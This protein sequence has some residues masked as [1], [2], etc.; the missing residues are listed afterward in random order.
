MKMN[1]ITGGELIF[2]QHS[3]VRWIL[4]NRPRQRNALG[5]A[6]YD[7]LIAVCRQVNADPTIRAMVLAGA[8]HVFAAATDIAL[9][10]DFKT[11]QEAMDDKA[12]GNQ[13]VGTVESV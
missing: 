3:A 11:E 13:V 10:Q 7:G 6:M 9:I 12:H 2:E 8:D 1:Q 5:G 4:F